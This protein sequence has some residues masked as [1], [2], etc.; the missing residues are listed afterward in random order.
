VTRHI[1]SSDPFDAF[2]RVSGTPVDGQM[3][4]YS[5]TS[6]L[7]EVVDVPQTPME[8]TPFDRF[9]LRDENGDAWFVRIVAGQLVITE[10]EPALVSNTSVGADLTP[11]LPDGWQPGDLLLVFGAMQATNAVT[12]DGFEMLWSYSG[13]SLHRYWAAYRYLEAG[14]TEVNIVT[15][16]G[17]RSHRLV[18]FRE[19]QLLRD[20]LGDVHAVNVGGSSG[21]FTEVASLPG[22][23]YSII[24]GSNYGNSSAPDLIST[25]TYV[26]SW[27]HNPSATR[28]R[29]YIAEVESTLHEVTYSWTGGERS[30]MGQVVIVSSYLDLV[31][32]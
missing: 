20:S 1:I 22:A 26:S 16:G 17:N 11:E 21:T 25:D 7:W 6:G 14:D 4:R 5:A 3:L 32:E 10:P 28:H 27:L 2:E 30:G 31:S 12:V 29:G 18:L 19:A 24:A 9:M 23:G 8:T 13:A 15:G